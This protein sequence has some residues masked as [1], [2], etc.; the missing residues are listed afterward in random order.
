MK[1]HS[2]LL[3]LLIILAMTVTTAFVLI[4]CDDNGYTPT[5]QRWTVTF[6]THGGSP[7]TS[8]TVDNNTTATRP[9]TNPT[10]DGYT[11]V[12]WYTA[13][14]DGQAFNFATPITSNTIIHARWITIPLADYANFIIRDDNVLTS[15]SAQG[16]EQSILVVPAGVT[17]IGPWAFQ[18]A[19]TFTSITIPASVT[20][21]HQ[22]AFLN[23]TALETVI[24]ESGSMLTTI[25]SGAFQNAT[26]LTSITIPA[27]VTDIMGHAFNNT[28]ALSSITIPASVTDIRA[29]AFHG[30]TVV[31]T[32][33]VVGHSSRP[34]GW[35]ENWLGDTPSS[36]VVWNYGG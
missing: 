31:Q 36:I 17:T 12:D 3:T 14:T 9:P 23:A 19:T 32:I 15:L 24:F 22:A 25:A 10:R 35:Y 21:I 11:F 18:N 8:Q 30:W 20:L 4:A 33:N 26:A 5:T 6:N 2:K 1:K 29:S 16:R 7:I 34:D 13:Q 27:S 28:T